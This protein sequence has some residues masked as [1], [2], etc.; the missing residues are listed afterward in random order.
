MGRYLLSRHNIPMQN[1]FDDM[2]QMSTWFASL[3]RLNNTVEN[4]QKVDNWTLDAKVYKL[5][6]L[7]VCL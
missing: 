7:F 4:T 2:E 3:R 6:F 1:T 5:L